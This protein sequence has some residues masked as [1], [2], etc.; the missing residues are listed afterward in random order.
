[1]A[2]GDSYIEPAELADFLKMTSSENDEFL[3][4]AV[5]AVSEWINQWCGRDFNLAA[6]ATPRVFDP[7]RDGTVWL[8]DI[9]DPAITVFTD[10]GLDGSFA[11]PWTSGDFQ[12]GPANALELG[13]P[14]ESMVASGDLRFPSSSKRTGLVRVSARWGWPA[15]PSVVKNACNIQAARIYKRRESAEGVLGFGDF[16]PVRVGVRLDPDVEMLLQTYRR[17]PTVA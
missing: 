17:P 4:L 1:M 6:T 13:K 5:A 8:D 14:I 10:S 11:T 16:G 15:V 3:L 12:T 9:G 2:L 7:Y